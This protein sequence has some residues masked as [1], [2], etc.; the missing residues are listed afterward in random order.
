MLDEPPT[1]ASASFPT[2][3][4]YHNRIGGIINLLEQSSKQDR[5]KEKQKLFPDHAL[6]DLVYGGIFLIFVLFHIFYFPLRV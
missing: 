2:K 4:A 6:C 3:T 5:K 1:A